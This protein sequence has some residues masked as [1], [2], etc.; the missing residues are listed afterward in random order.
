MGFKVESFFNVNDA[1]GSKPES[2]DVHNVHSKCTI[3]NGST[4]TYPIERILKCILSMCKTLI[5]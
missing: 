4:Q 2:T 3:F 5:S 1:Y